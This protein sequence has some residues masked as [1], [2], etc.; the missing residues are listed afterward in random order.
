MNA[1]FRHLT[2]DL[3][4]D[5]RE[6]D[7]PTR[8]LYEPALPEASKKRR[9]HAPLEQTTSNRV[10]VAGC[11]TTKVDPTELDE[12]INGWNALLLHDVTVEGPGARAFI[13]EFRQHCLAI[14]IAEPHYARV[15]L[16]MCH[17]DAAI[18]WL[19]RR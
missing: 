8:I 19:R 2:L 15:L 11:R 18:E 13:A 6:R 3:A 12:H 9:F 4:L 14:L 5:L 16:P 10:A 1:P 17:S 7:E